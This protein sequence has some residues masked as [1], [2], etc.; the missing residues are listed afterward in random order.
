MIFL[1]KFDCYE[2]FILVVK[3]KDRKDCVRIIEEYRT[4]NDIDYN[5]DIKKC[6]NRRNGI[7][8]EEESVLG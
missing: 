7:L 5:Y 2:T 1:V 3:A 4:E 8:I 6:K